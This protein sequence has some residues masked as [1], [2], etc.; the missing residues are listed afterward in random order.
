MN[1]LSEIS[2]ILAIIA[3]VAAAVIGIVVW[4]GE[5][6]NRSRVSFLWVALFIGVWIATNVLFANDAG[7]YEFAVAL[8]SY[9]AAMLAVVQIFA[10]CLGLVRQ[11]SPEPYLWTIII[12][13]YIAAIVS[14]IPGVVGTGVIDL[15]VQTHPL[16]LAIYGIILVAYII[17]SCVVLIVARHRASGVLK[18]RIKLVLYGIVIA[19]AIG[20]S[21]NLL[22]P[23]LN[24]YAFIQLGPAGAVAFVA[25]VAYSI[26]KYSL[27]DVRLAIV[28]TITYIMAIA[29]LGAIYVL[30]VYLIFGALLGQT[31]NT[32]Q[33]VLS[34]VLAFGL[35]F[36][37]P[38]VKRF[39][40][41]LTSAIFYRDNYNNDEFF[42]RL[43]DRLSATTDLRHLLEIIA[44]E[45]A[46]T[47]KAEHAYFFVYGEQRHHMTAGTD[48]HG[49]LP[50][51]D[52][53]TIRE[54][55]GV[56]DRAIVTTLLG[57]S[58]HLRRLLI[59]HKIEVVLPLIRSGI[60]I[61]FF[62][63]GSP[64]ASKYT[65]RDIRVLETIS[66]ELVIA[67]ENA[68]SIQEVRELNSTLQQRVSSATKELRA[69][70]NQLKRLDEAKDEFVS[71]ASHQLRT[72]LTSVKGYISMVLEGDAGKIALQQK[73]LLTEAF[74]SSE[75]MVRLIN[76]F[77]DVSRLQTGKFIIDKRPVD[78]AKII[79]QEIESLQN[80]AA[81]RK[82]KFVYKAPKKFPILNLDEG[83]IRQVI[84]NYAD[85]AIYYSTDT[86]TI[87][88]SLSV[89]GKDAVFTVKDAGIGVPADEQA[90][91]FTKFYRA[92]NARKQRPDGTGVGLF[93]AKKVIDAHG[94]TVIFDSVE[95]R[96]STFGFRLPVDKLSVR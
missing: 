18:H 72:P 86:S 82:L 61:G 35:G 83:K 52:V 69:S 60:V 27:F 15:K 45:I 91:L 66:A 68:L 93:L 11:R 81:S 22:L 46:G 9:A 30:V 85:N 96:G 54:Y 53:T 65:S 36:L 47:I 4:F 73:K 59:S 89:K 62:Y 80:N 41:R 84:M 13:G 24:I 19:G 74:S 90:D 29:S 71:M 16:G 63:L 26:V 51:E 14:A 44:R 34:A 70:N 78:L 88:V 94:G 1:S 48:H 64:L 23:L 6:Q 58:N 10:L 55:I 92:S 7:P 42:G 5:R 95:G 79:N 17:S 28:R 56:N 87:H 25:A 8:V 2:S 76:D 43:N 32:L 33:N 21:C 20:V 75:R 39:F 40:D 3:A 50:M 38:S 49:T 31:T 77:L 37:F 67:I 57:Q 12:A